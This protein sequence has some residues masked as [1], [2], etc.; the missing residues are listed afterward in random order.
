MFSRTVPQ[1]ESEE[2][3][4]V[5]AP[6]AD[7]M[8]GVVF[9]FIVLM[10]ALVMNL[11]REETVPRS[12]YEALV[13]RAQSLEDR[14]AT[15]TLRVRTLE[16]EK[17]QL[18]Q[19]LDDEIQRREAAEA[20]VRAL[21]EANVR[22]IAFVRFVQEN[23]LVRLV[24]RLAE[25]GQTRAEVLQEI[26][27]ILAQSN[28]QVRVNSDAGTLMLPAGELF[29]SGQPAPTPAGVSQRSKQVTFTS[30]LT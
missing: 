18:A 7:L 9:I 6:V 14:L 15:E 1:T 25:A 12:T 10:L 16:A 22:L 8:V 4:D 2:A 28:I 19:R 3:K 13:A 11:R 29:G 21:E 17:A 20:R 24:Q 30:P 27:S 5:F 23:N 26:R